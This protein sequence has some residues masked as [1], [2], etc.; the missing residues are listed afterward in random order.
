M[1]VNNTKNQLFVIVFKLDFL[2]FIIHINCME[3][4]SE[5]QISHFRRYPIFFCNDTMHIFIIEGGAANTAQRSY[6]RYKK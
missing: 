2:C 5:L 1:I 4:S 6:E 3:T